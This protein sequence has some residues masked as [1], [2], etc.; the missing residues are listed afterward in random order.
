MKSTL[1]ALPPPRRG[2]RSRALLT[3]GAGQFGL[4]MT[5]LAVFALLFAMLFLRLVR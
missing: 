3:L 5:F 1:L 2:S 4:V